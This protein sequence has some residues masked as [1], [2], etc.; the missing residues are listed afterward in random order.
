ME[1]SIWGDGQRDLWEAI[2]TERRRGWKQSTV[3]LYQFCSL[4]L[5][6]ASVLFSLGKSCCFHGAAVSSLPP[7]HWC[8]LQADDPI[9]PNS[10]LSWV[11][12][13]SEQVPGSL[14]GME[15]LSESMRDFGTDSDKEEDSQ[16]TIA[17]PQDSA[18]I[19]ATLDKVADALSA[20]ATPQPVVDV[21][22]Q[23]SERS[24]TPEPSPQNNLIQIVEPSP[25]NVQPATLTLI[26]ESHGSR[27]PSALE[28]EVACMVCRRI[29]P[30]SQPKS[31]IQEDATHPWDGP[32]LKGPPLK[33][34][35]SDLGACC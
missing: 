29:P 28:R 30:C 9:E 33:S 1:D 24:G 23:I 22:E 34:W 27:R 31:A 7:V 26:P 15:F 32:S 19:A 4:L 5:W 21:P 18:H 16:P 3:P 20:T 2:L 11:L 6:D 17:F 8:C 10:P 25:H 12:S 13:V 35:T 14:E